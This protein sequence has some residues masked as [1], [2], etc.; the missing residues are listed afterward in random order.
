MLESPESK[1]EKERLN[2]SR[3]LAANVVITVKL[4]MNMA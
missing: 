1:E 3:T 2:A 4:K